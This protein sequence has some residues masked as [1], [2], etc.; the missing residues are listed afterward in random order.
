MRSPKQVDPFY[1]SKEWHRVRQ[2]ALI[3][4]H[5][6]CVN[7]GTDVRA[8]GA[9][10]VDHIRPRKKYPDLALHLPNLR[11]LCVPCDNA[12]A[13]SRPPLGR[14]WQ[15]GNAGGRRWVPCWNGLE[16]S[17]FLADRSAFPY[18]ARPPHSPMRARPPHSPMRARPPHSPIGARHPHSPIGARPPHSP[19]G[20]RRVPA[21]VM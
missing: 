5:F 18:G 19:I 6:S 9:S 11:T 8:K 1:K 14:W 10:R 17:G 15:R 20:A 13:C 7:C 16:R 2:K 3:R 21:D 4:D 12:R